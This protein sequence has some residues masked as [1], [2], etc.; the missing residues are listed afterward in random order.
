[1]RLDFRAMRRNRKLQKKWICRCRCR[2]KIAQKKP[3]F[4]LWIRPAARNCVK[5]PNSPQNAS[6]K[7]APLAGGCTAGWRPSRRLEAA[8]QAGGRTAGWRLR[9]MLEAAPEAVFYLALPI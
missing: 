5:S 9:C 7:A 3:E 6:Q 1:M 4:G 8:P 2:R